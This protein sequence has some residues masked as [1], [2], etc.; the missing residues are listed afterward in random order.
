VLGTRE[1]LRVAVTMVT[2]VNAANFLTELDGGDELVAR[3]LAPY[4]DDERTVSDLL[5]DQAEFAAVLVLNKLDLVGPDEARRL[6]AA[7]SRLNPEA[8]VVPAVDARLLAPGEPV[9]A[10]D[11]FP[12]GRRTA[13]RT[14]ASTNT[15]RPHRPPS[16]SGPAVVAATA[17]SGPA[18]RHSPLTRRCPT[19]LAEPGVGIPSATPR[20]RLGRRG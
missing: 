19:P 16:R 12:P 14:P 4:E 7:L 18:V 5:V 10:E 17:P 3:G 6:R 20:R 1:G 15:W 9:P 8:R 2:V 11:D 13:S